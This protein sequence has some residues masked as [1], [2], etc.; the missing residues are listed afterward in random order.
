MKWV[1]ENDTETESP[2]KTEEPVVENEI[3]LFL[4]LVAGSIAGLVGGFVRAF[5]FDEIDFGI[6]LYCAFIPF[7]VPLLGV[8]AAAFIWAL[9][10]KRLNKFA[11]L[12]T[13]GIGF[14]AGFLPFDYYIPF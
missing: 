8:V 3:S 11:I 5:F 7:L 9:F 14:F 2:K 1:V 13:L 4:Y 6:D 12:L 10:N